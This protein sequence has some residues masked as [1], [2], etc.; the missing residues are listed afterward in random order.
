VDQTAFFS[1]WWGSVFITIA[2][3]A[4]FAGLAVGSALIGRVAD[5]WKHTLTLY[6]ALETGIAI[7]GVVATIALS[8][9]AAPFVS[10]QTRFGFLAWILPFLL[11]GLPAVLMGGT[12]PV[13]MRWQRQ[14][15]KP[16]AKA[17]G[18]I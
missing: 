10:M 6:A 13:A 8:H 4:F 5:R 15:V 16:I 9:A 17:G 11:V 18:W 1:S 14:S 2:V 3:S 12:L 7:T